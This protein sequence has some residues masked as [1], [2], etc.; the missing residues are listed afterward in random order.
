MTITSRGVIVPWMYGSQSG[1][2]SA[3]GGIRS[4]V[5]NFGALIH[6][7]EIGYPAQTYGHLA[8]T[9]G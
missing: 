2:S 8:A 7:K 9:R 1:I 3:R 5:A 4:L 6:G